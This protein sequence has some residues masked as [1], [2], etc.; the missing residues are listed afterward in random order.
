M[1]IFVLDKKYREALPILPILLFANF[2]LGLYYN[3]SAWYRIKDKTLYGTYIT[4]FGA[5]VTLISNYLLIPMYGYYGAAITHA[6]TY[7]TMT[8]VCYFIGQSFFPVPYQWKK[9]IFYFLCTLVFININSLLTDQFD[10]L[11]LHLIT[12]VL[13]CVLFVFISWR[14][15]FRNVKTELKIEN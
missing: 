4:L 7:F 2:C 10:S 14:L 12:S 1:R 3:I 9:I 15:D 13:F 11:L 6:L 8:L 5:S